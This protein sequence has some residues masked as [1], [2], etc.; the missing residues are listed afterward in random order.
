MV[1]ESRLSFHGGSSPRKG[2][3]DR[4]KMS[5]SE[6]SDE[7]MPKDLEVDLPDEASINATFDFN[8]LLVVRVELKQVV[9]FYGSA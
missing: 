7:S 9:A 3:G 5:R 6:S 8:T 4:A 1:N 2:E